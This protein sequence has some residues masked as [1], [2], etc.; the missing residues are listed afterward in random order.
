[1]PESQMFVIGHGANHPIASNAS[2]QGK[3]RNRRV[4]FVVYPERMAMR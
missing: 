2:D 1:M 3:A 4:E